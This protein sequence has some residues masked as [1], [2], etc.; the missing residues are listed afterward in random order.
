MH[1]VVDPLLIVALTLNF[2]ALGVSRIRGVINAVALQGILLGILPFF[3]H[4]DPEHWLRGVLLIGVTIALKGFVIPG[5]LVH[6]MREADIQHEVTPVVNY[7]T[8]LLLGAIGTGLAI[9]FAYTLPLAEKD[10][11]SLV[12]PASFSTVWIGFLLLTTRKKA[13]M[14]VLGYLI[15]ENGIFL[16]GLLLLE[17]MPFLVE[18]G[19]LL[20]LFTGVFVMGIIIHHINR[21]FA[22]T[23]TENLAELKE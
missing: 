13:I 22:S 1:E 10:A 7:M 8:S 19:V 20:D 14:Q 5:F 11:G 12:V 23:D 15:L 16:F 3:I 9:V 6:A 21:E 17:A 4:S 18:I 2:V